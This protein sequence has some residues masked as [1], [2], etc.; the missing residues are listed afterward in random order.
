ML[1]VARGRKPVE[2]QPNNMIL[3]EWVMERWVQGAILEASDPRLGGDFEVE[4]MELVL[5][6]GLLCSH[7]N[8]VARPSMMQ[9][10]QYL[11]GDATLPKVMADAIGPG[12]FSVGS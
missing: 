10:M 6:L 9:V 12:M 11:N 7:S 4:E 1:V 5:T 8:P 3:A 2:P